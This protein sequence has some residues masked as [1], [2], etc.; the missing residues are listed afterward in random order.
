MGPIFSVLPTADIDLQTMVVAFKV[1]ARVMEV[2]IFV[3]AC[4]EWVVVGIGT[5]VQKQLV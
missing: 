2:F 5:V 1:V 3:D 4:E